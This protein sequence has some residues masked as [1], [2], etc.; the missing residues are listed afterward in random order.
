M[1]S[2]F[3]AGKQAFLSGLTQNDNPYICGL[4]KLGNPKFSDQEAGADWERGF[5]SAKPERVASAK[6]IAAARSVD[7]SRFRR[8]SNRYYA[9]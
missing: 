1:T 2:D 8:K 3:E 4:T 7:V 5:I 6:E 9:K